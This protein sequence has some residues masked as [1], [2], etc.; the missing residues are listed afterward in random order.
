MKRDSEMFIDDIL[1]A[2]IVRYH[3]IERQS[4]L[5]HYSLPFNKSLLK[6]KIK[7]IS[8]FNDN[9]LIFLTN[10]FHV[11]SCLFHASVFAHLAFTLNLIFIE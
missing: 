5:F 10:Q 3:Q 8:H 11:S 2:L 9:F 1:L 7:T 6:S 4:D